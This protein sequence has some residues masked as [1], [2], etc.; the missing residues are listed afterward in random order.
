MRVQGFRLHPIWGSSV[1][2]VQLEVEIV[3]GD[4]WWVVLLHEVVHHV[5]LVVARDLQ[6][7]VQGP[8][9]VVQV[10]VAGVRSQ[11]SWR[12]CCSLYYIVN[13]RFKRSSNAQMFR[14]RSYKSRTV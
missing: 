14:S 11:E 6:D 8:D 5:L 4:V 9:R 13:G 3:V 7:E 10:V 12:S 2:V 1:V